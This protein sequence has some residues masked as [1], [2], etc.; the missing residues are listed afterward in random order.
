MSLRKVS[1]AKNIL[2]QSSGKK[3]KKKSR[4]DDSSSDETTE[5][6]DF[7]TELALQCGLKPKHL[8]LKDVV[9]LDQLTPELWM[10]FV[11]TMN[12]VIVMNALCLVQQSH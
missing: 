9:R 12:D 4:K 3:K 7:H 1:L 10:Q 8:K 6:E 5:G 11:S 2:S